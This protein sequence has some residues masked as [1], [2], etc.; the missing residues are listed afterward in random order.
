MTLAGPTYSSTT[1]TCTITIGQ[2]D[3]STVRLTASSTGTCPT[4]GYIAPAYDQAT[5]SYHTSCHSGNACWQLQ[6][7]DGSDYKFDA[8]T[9][10]LVYVVDRV[11]NTVTLAYSSGNLS[12]VTAQSGLRSL[13]FSWTGSHISSVTDSLGRQV[14]FGYDGS[15]DLN[16]ITMTATND[17]VTHYLQFTSNTTSHLL[18]DWWSPAND[19][20]G[21]SPSSAVETAVT[22]DA[23]NRAVEV[24][25]PQRSCV[26]GSST[27][28]CNP[29][30]SF[31]WQSFNQTTGTGSVLVSDPNENAALSAGNV[32]LDT[33]ADRAL[34][35][36][37]GGYG[38]GMLAS[39]MSVSV[40][41][42]ASLLP[43]E[44]IDGN[45]NVTGTLFDGAGNALVTT[46][47]LGRA[48]TGEY[49]GFSETVAHV[50]AVGNET[51]W[52][53]DSTGDPDS[54]TDPEGNVTQSTFGSDAPEAQT[55]TDAINNTTTT[56]GYDSAGDLTST[57]DPDGD[58][59]STLYDGVGESCA[60]LSA[61]GY[62]AGY[63]IP[64]SCPMSGAYYL[65]VYPA[66][67]F[68]GQVL[69]KITP[70]NASGGTWQYGYDPDGNKTSVENPDLNT[71][72]YTY[73]SNDEQVSVALPAVVY[74]GLNRAPTTTY[75]YDPSGNQVTTT[76]PMGNLSGCGCAAQHTWTTA[77][78]NLGRETSSTDPLS[79]ATN[80]TYDANGNQLKL[81][82]PRGLTTTSTYDVD[83]EL[84]ARTD[85]AGD[86]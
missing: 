54:S 32:T 73:D 31:T 12:T 37:V 74:N 62:A 18:Q 43:V 42:T 14:A 44:A 63:T 61:N 39:T 19:P 85:G 47:P 52:T 76:K 72:S 23:S 57:T 70:T 68:F 53:Y 30:W 79:N 48:T 64:S 13:S 16:K 78:D 24:Q 33:Y 46:D 7:P 11:G 10:Q 21:S 29:E 49:N 36:Q 71:T 38:P 51:T 56:Y 66:Y 26:E 8:T 17:P 59:T 25:R 27:V 50:D 75:G 45:G 2:E 5:L 84:L 22:Y 35:S 1:G 34:V 55:T 81:T 80:Y 58:V 82:T 60:L 65:T 41:N 40:H 67:D 77:Y 6:R 3:G 9:N 86:E 83:N 28:N 15:G 20:T 69:T 4:S